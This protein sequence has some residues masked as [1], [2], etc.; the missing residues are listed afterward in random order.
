MIEDKRNR[1]NVVNQLE[2]RVVGLFYQIVKKSSNLNYIG[3][4]L[5]KQK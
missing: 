5:S 1:V 4:I 3:N 2:A